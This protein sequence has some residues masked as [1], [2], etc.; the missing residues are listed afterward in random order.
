MWMDTR[1]CPL[2]RTASLSLEPFKAI[3]A[4][5]G[6]SEIILESAVTRAIYH[7]GVSPHFLSDKDLPAAGLPP[8]KYLVTNNTPVPGT[9]QEFSLLI[10]GNGGRAM[11]RC[12][13]GQGQQWREAVTPKRAKK[14]VPPHGDTLCVHPVCFIY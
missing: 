4:P 2:H 9:R 8:H 1:S 10:E 13:G 6:H 11:T 5:R 3:L 7:L 12:E 14:S